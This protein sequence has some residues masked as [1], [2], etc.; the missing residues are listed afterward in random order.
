MGKLACV[1]ALCAVL[2]CSV[3]CAFQAPVIPPTGFLFTNYEA[4]LTT[5]FDETGVGGLKKGEASS[6][7]VLWLFAFGDCSLQAAAEQG[8]LSSINYCD[9]AY[10]NVLGV[11]Q[12]FTI[13]ARGK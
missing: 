5:E 13:V 11:Y 10:L 8:G 1:A 9:Y 12:K 4:P 7:C 3:G 2:A 6:M